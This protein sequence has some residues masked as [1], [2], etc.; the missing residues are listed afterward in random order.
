MQIPMDDV[1]KAW[2]DMGDQKDWQHLHQSLKDHKKQEGDEKGMYQEMIRA[3]DHLKDSGHEF[4]QSAEELKQEMERQLGGGEEMGEG[5][6]RS[7]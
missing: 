6:S 3:A 1:K 4:P 2:E 5:Q 7:M